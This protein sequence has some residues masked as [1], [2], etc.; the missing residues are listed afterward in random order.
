MCRNIKKS[1]CQKHRLREEKTQLGRPTRPGQNVLLFDIQG[2]S[3][4]FMI[5]FT[6]CTLEVGWS[7]MNIS[8]KLCLAK[9][10]I[11]IIPFGKF[12]FENNMLLLLRL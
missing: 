3:P 11:S 4:F 7:H 2:N 5:S 8:V 9:V 6:Q 1:M 12:C 10:K